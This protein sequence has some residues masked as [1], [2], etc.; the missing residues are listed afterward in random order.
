MTNFKPILLA[1]SLV[2]GSAAASSATVLD[3][4]GDIDCFGVGG[5]CTEG[6]RLDSFP[7]SGSSFQED[8]LI[9]GQTATWTHQFAPATYTNAV[10]EF[11]TVGLA[12]VNGP[13]DVFGDGTLIGTIPFDPPSN[14]DIQTYSFSVNSSLLLDGM[15]NISFTV[16]SSDGWSFDYS[17]LSGDLAGMAPVPLPAGGLLLLTGLG[18][19]AA[20]KRRKKRAA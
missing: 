17:Q 19:I 3:T 1:A 8:T 12:D 20:L 6:T 7:P 5:A 18:G 2:V 16:D 13:Y 14:F 9:A 11:R 15:L 4:F 10:L